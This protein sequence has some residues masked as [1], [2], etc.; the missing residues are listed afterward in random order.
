MQTTRHLPDVAALAILGITGIAYGG[1]PFVTD[2]PEP[3]ELH[4]WEFYIASMHSELGGDWSGTA[5]HFELNY[6]AVP[7]LQLHTIVPLAYDSPP[8]GPVRY[9]WGDVELGAKYRFV[10][11]TNGW[12]QIGAFP[13]I[14]IPSGSEREN[15]GNGHAQAFIPLWVQKSWG[16]WT[17]YGGGGYGINSFSGH[18]N[19]GYV[20]GVLQKQ[21]LT[22]LLIGVEIYHQTLYQTDFPN[23]GTAFNIGTVYDFTDNHHLL[24]SI[25]R[26]IDG[27]IGFQCYIAYQLTFEKSLFE[28]GEHPIGGGR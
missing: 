8:D 3:V 2:D 19:W 9:G 28:A 5:P 26:S 15:L 17:A 10:Q 27:P 18:N 23:Q 25:G 6:G 7:D 11:E 22:N 13:L 4:H 21:V 24:F 14:E 20:G 16:P 1:P 12:P